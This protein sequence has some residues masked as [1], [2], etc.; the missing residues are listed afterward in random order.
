MGLAR[1]HLGETAIL[2][3]TGLLLIGDIHLPEFRACRGF[4]F[5]RVPTSLPFP[6]RSTP[7]G[8]RWNLAWER[9]IHVC[10]TRER[11]VGLMSGCFSILHPCML[12][13]TPAVTITSRHG[14]IPFPVL[15][16]VDFGPGWFNPEADFAVQKSLNAPGLSPPFNSEF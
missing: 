6:T 5:V 2:F 14:I 13:G 1:Q 4:Q 11:G 15:R 3:T 9:D 10:P 7:R 16:A 8:L 12:Q